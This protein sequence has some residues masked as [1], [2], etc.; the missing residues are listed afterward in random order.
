MA[1]SEIRPELLQFIRQYI[2]S[3]EHLEVLLL[4]SALPD[5]SWT[6]EGI[7][8]V[9]QSSV[10]AVTERVLELCRQGFLV[11]HKQEGGAG[12][13]QFQP[14]SEE[15]R[16]LVAELAATYRERRVRVIEAIYAPPSPMD[17]F[18]RAFRLRKD[19]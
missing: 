13:Y 15:L 1:Q 5:R 7:D 9:I 19:N 18:S 2:P 3:V 11:E 8:Q 4:V 12:R 14:N 10:S 17:E 6:V 16:R